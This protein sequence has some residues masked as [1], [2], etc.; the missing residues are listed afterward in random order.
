ME[1][2][3]TIGR[4][5]A[6][7]MV[8]AVVA[9]SAGNGADTMAPA[10]RAGSR[11]ALLGQY[12]IG[13]RDVL[14]VR[15]DLERGKLWVLGLDNVYVFEITTRRLARKFA[16]P[17]WSVSRFDCKPDLA[18]D[19]TGTAWISSNAEARLWRITS[20][21]FSVSERKLLL[22]GRD[23][24]DVGFGAIAFG[25]DG[26]LFAMTASAGGQLWKIDPRDGEG[27]LV[28]IGSLFPGRCEFTDLFAGV[29]AVTLSSPSQLPQE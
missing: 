11:V 25:P 15:A 4:F 14:R 16:L 24:W 5:V 10:D 22:R 28:E 26:W 6:G 21:D 12:G 18:I 23:L 7:L 8:M 13:E 19:S 2:G 3:M 20:G 1:N 29:A 9:C 17:G 27:S